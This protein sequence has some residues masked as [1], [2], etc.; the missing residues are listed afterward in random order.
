[1]KPIVELLILILSV[2]VESFTVHASQQSPLS[3]QRPLPGYKLPSV[4]KAFRRRSLCLKEKDTEETPIPETQG[5]RIVVS[6]EIDLPF[7]A[8]VA[9][10][11]FSDLPRQPSWSPWLSSVK[12]I[13]STDSD[14]DTPVS[15]WNMKYLGVGISWECVSTRLERPR[16]IGWQSIRGLKNFGQVVFES[17]GPDRT[18]MK[19][20]LTFVTPRFVVRLMGGEHGRVAQ[21][22]EKKILKN[23][24]E[25]FK[26]VVL[27]NDLSKSPAQV[28]K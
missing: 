11:A 13:E 10:D 24:L 19:L 5:N 23:T 28:T 3:F 16:V 2:R 25:R 1:M 6:S 18:H 4:G 9:F 17:A 8:D 7:S 21:V 20:T 26:K 22:V 12:Y 14:R 15:K 27:E